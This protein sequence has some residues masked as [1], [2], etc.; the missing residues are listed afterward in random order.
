MAWQLPRP[1]FQN[2]M[3][4]GPRSGILSMLGWMAATLGSTMLGT[5]AF[6]APDWMQKLAGG[7]FA[8]NFFVFICLYIYFSFTDKDALRSERHVIQKLAITNNLIGD[9]VAGL[10]DPLTELSVTI[11]PAITVQSSEGSQ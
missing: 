8:V 6:H 7:M 1:L 5:V 9:S 2:Q 3:Q 4:G 10:F 11:P